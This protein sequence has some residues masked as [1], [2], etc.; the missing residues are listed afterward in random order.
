MKKK[1]L[2]LLL[3]ILLA[4]NGLS[5]CY[6]GGEN[7]KE[8]VALSFGRFFQ[9]S[10]RFENK[11]VAFHNFDEKVER[12]GLVTMEKR[13]IANEMEIQAML[14]KKASFILIAVPDFMCLCWKNFAE[15]ALY[16]YTLK[17]AADVYIV[18]AKTILKH[19]EWGVKTAGNNIIIALMGDGKAKFQETIKENSDL[20][21]SERA[22]SKWIS[23]RALAPRILRV[24]T[25]EDL[26][27]LKDTA[28]Y[29]VYY[30]GRTSCPDCTYF[31]ST[32]LFD[33]YKQKKT[34]TPYIY[35]IDC[36][37]EGRR[38]KNGQFDQEQ[39]NQYKVD[40]L[41]AQSEDNPAGYGSGFVPTLMALENGNRISAMDVYLNDEV[42]QNEDGD[43]VVTASY[44]DESR[45][46]ASYLNYVESAF[47]PWLKGKNLGQYDGEKNKA[48][49][50]YREKLSAYHNAITTAF[51]ETFTNAI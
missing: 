21:T 20:Q 3:P 49:Y 35:Y 24:D 1:S 38:F 27:A 40:H 51:L 6:L 45:K 9:E 26:I 44:F 39:W 48:Y 15:G 10:A 43:Y 30:Y 5:S 12:N 22:L 37:M 46:G 2:L 50:W 23:S 36:D 16:E 34:E 32:F 4:F 47:A 28:Y 8:K 7:A 17:N 19:E 13:Y 29:H 31:E 18:D 41:L 25:E 42:S 11:Y 14:D 33:Y